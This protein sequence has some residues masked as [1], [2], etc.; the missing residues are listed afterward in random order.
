MK[1]KQNKNP[2]EYHFA[3]YLIITFNTSNGGKDFL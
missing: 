1:T 2:I 3:I